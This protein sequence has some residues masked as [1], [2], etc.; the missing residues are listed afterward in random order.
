MGAFF[1]RLITRVEFKNPSSTR[2]KVP[3]WNGKQM[4]IRCI[5]FSVYNNF[6]CEIGF[7]LE[8]LC[9][10]KRHDK[11][12]Y[13]YPL[14]HLKTVKHQI[15]V[16]HGKM[17]MDVTPKM[18]RTPT[19]IKWKIHSYLFYIVFQVLKVLLIKICKIPTTTRSFISFCFY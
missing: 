17:G 15:D 9:H 8:T 16:L 3:W 2:H 1:H 19:K 10:T 6:S 5:I 7:S 11:N 12:I 18:D 14:I 4:C 13:F